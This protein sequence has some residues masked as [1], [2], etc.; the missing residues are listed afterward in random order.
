[1]PKPLEQW[2]DGELVA[3]RTYRCPGI[4]DAGFLVFRYGLTRYEVVII[5]IPRDREVASQPLASLRA[6]AR[7]I[8]GAAEEEW[9]AYR[10]V[11]GP[12]DAILDRAGDVKVRETN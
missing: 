10:A 4:A 5:D 3:N 12:L 2:R 11:Q 6:V 1:V 9:K 7:Y 8:R